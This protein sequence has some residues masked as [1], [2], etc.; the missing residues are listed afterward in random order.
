VNHAIRAEQGLLPGGGT[1]EAVLDEQAG[2]LRQQVI[3]TM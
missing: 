1:D 3:E 2:R